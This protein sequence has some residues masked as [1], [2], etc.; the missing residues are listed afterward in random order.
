MRILSLWPAGSIPSEDTLTVDPRNPHARDRL[1]DVRPAGPISARPPHGR[2]PERVLLVQVA[3][4]EVQGVSPGLLLHLLRQL[5]RLGRAHRLASPRAL[6]PQE[7]LHALAVGRLGGPRR[8]PAAARAGEAAWGARPGRAG[9]PED[10]RAGAGAVV[11]VARQELL[12]RG[13]ED[14]RARRARVRRAGGQRRV[15]ADLRPGDRGGAPR[16]LREPDARGDPPDSTRRVAHHRQARLLA[17]RGLEDLDGNRLRLPG[18]RRAGPRARLED[19]EGA[20]GRPPPGRE[21]RALRADEVGRA[22]GRR[23]RRAGLPRGERRGGGARGGA[24]RG[25]GG[26]GGARPLRGGDAREHRRPARPGPERGRARGLPAGG[27]SRSLQALPLPATVREA[28]ALRVLLH[29]PVPRQLLVERRVVE[30]GEL[31]RPGDAPARL[32]EP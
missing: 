17:L 22:G 24:G 21:L 8:D 31:G 9:D 11:G 23:G 16:L 5:G 25:E 14:R 2:P 1:Y 30:A 29:Q 15:E 26:R 10:A 32:A 7:A 4:R 20:R 27:G 6:R 3:T 28:L 12:A 18:S 19:G 13:V